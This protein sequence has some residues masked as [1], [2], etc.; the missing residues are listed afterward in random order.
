MARIFFSYAHDD[1]DKVQKVKKALERRGHEIWL[2]KFNIQVGIS[3]P[4]AIQ[5]GINN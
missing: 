1:A 5:T 2:D 3:I 4:Q